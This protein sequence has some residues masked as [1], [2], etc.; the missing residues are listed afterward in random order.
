MPTALPHPAPTGVL[1]IED[2]A[3]IRLMLRATLEA[4]GHVVFEAGTAHD[5]ARLAEDPRV[6]L[7]LV[8]LGLP[9]EDGVALIRSLR[10]WTRRP[11][12]VV[13]AGSS[14]AQMVRAL[15]AG[16]DDYLIKPLGLAELHARLRAVMR[17]SA[18]GVQDGRTV[19]NLG[20][21]RIDLDARLVRS[22][23]EPVSLTAT[24]WRLLEVL[25]REAGRV[26]SARQLLQEVWGPDHGERGHYLR[27]YIHRLRQLIEP[28][29]ARP[30]YIVNEPG[31]G[32]RL[33]PD[34]L[35]AA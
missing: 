23:D 2:E 16:A 26:V 14:Q 18:A 33:L 24:Q 12:V 5:G 21:V 29:P 30:C 31:I 25:C 28:T 7:I 19:V 8:D 20:R 9:D 34:E 11:I 22:N 1:V 13:S 35:P 27:I 17:R 3:S 32:Y 10:G 15:D 6:G 4:E